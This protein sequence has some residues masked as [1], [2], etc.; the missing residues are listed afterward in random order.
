MVP[1]FNKKSKC[2]QISQEVSIIPA[3]RSHKKRNIVVLH[4]RLASGYDLLTS[5]VLVVESLTCHIT[6][7]AFLLRAGPSWQC[8]S[9]RASSSLD[10]RQYESTKEKGS[11]GT[12]RRHTEEDGHPV[13]AGGHASNNTCSD[14]G[15]YNHI[16]IAVLQCEDVVL[17]CQGE[18]GRC[19]GSYKDR[20]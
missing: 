12:P 19:H 17:D 2:H 18:A 5:E 10:R 16:S 20:E 9:E 14:D 3:S 4:I 8:S 7:L 6:L 11:N 15:E 1:A 13:Q